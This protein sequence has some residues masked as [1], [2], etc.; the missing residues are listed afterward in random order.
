MVGVRRRQGVVFAKHVQLLKDFCLNHLL[1]PSDRHG[2]RVEAGVK[3]VVV[4]VQVD[5]LDGGKL[6]NVQDILGVDGVRIRDELGLFLAS[7]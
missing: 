2:A 5:A 3:G 1:L 4:G 7:L 6:F